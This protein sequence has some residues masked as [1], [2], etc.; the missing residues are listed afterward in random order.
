MKSKSTPNFDGPY[1]RGNPYVKVIFGPPRTFL[2]ASRKKCAPL[3]PK[4]SQA[5]AMGLKG[6]KGQH[7]YGLTFTF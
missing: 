5:M 2:Y 7:L 1:L 3:P 4:K 6:D